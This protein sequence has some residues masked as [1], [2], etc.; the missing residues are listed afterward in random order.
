MSKSIAILGLGKYGRSLAENLSEMGADVLV[1]DRKEELIRDFATKVTSAVCVDLADEEE[2]KFLGLNNMDIVV[3]AMGQDL[4]PSIMCVA[5]AKEAGVPFILAKAS[6]H[7]MATLLR[8]VGADKVIDPEEESGLRSARI[9]MSSSVFD[10]FQLDKNLGLA[11]ILPEPDWVGKTLRQ[12]DLRKKH[13][14]NVVAIKKPDGSW[15]NPRPD[16]KLQAD[17]KLL[18]I[19]TQE[20]LKTM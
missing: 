12:L 13:E 5:M 16:Q 1:A 9:I 8:R 20:Q 14:I 6:S 2:L 19:A 15:Q 10:F 3:T 18:V 11:E 4:A 7:R 17:E